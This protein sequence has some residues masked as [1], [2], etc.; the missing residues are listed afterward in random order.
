MLA[1]FM[2]CLGSLGFVFAY[3]WVKTGSFFVTF[4]G[5]T[6]VLMSF[7]V[8]FFIY[9]FVFD[10]KLFG[11]LQVCG[12]NCL[13]ACC[14]TVGLCKVLSLFIILGIGAD[15]IFVL[16]DAFRQASYTEED[17]IQQDLQSRL[18]WAYKRANKAMFITS[19]TR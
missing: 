13:C 11:A 9:R 12:C 7:P 3:M 15:D 8:C 4:L 6:Q 14:V 2:L 1:D 19:M 10:I 17:F 5:V 16:L 18:T